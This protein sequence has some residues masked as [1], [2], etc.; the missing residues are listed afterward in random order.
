MKAKLSRLS[1]L[2]VFGGVGMLLL[3]AVLFT[4]AAVVDDFTVGPLLGFS[5]MF[6]LAGGGFLLF[7]GIPLALFTHLG[8]AARYQAEEL[9]PLGEDLARRGMTLNE[10]LAPRAAKLLRQVAPDIAAAN[11]EIVRGIARGARKGWEEGK[12]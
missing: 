5:G 12:P 3:G 4:S 1:K 9:V 6:V 2:L 7:F 11:E 8:S 10:E